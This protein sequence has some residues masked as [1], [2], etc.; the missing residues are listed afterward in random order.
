VSPEVVTRVVE[1][2][3]ARFNGRPLREFVPLKASIWA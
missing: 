1:E 3:H 2:E